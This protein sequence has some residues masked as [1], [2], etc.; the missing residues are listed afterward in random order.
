MKIPSILTEMISDIYDRKMT[1]V[2]DRWNRALTEL[3]KFHEFNFEERRKLFADIEHL[4]HGPLTGYEV[5]TNKDNATVTC[6]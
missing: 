6:F 1:N 5:N 4:A 3:S 2:S